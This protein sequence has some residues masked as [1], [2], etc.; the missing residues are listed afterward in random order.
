MELPIKKLKLSYY[1]KIIPD[2]SKKDFKK[3]KESIEKWGIIEPIVINQN[4][5][6][7]CGKERYRAALVLGIAKVPVVIRKTNG[8]G[9][10]RDISLE[11]NLRRRHL[12]SSIKTKEIQALYELK[13]IKEEERKGR[14]KRKYTSSRKAINQVDNF[15]KHFP[16][17]RFS[18]MLIPAL[19]KLLD[20]RKINRESASVYA[21]L[22]LENQKRIYGILMDNLANSSSLKTKGSV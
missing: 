5:V 22:S 10:I 1:E 11:E 7:V 19:S 14:K 8:D 20:K 13:Q 16:R 12:S 9:E 2:L 4:N 17:C 18:A 6:I 15:E 3:L 21:K